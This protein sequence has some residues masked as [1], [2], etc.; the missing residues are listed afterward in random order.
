MWRYRL[1]FASLYFIQGATLAYIVNFQKPY[2]FAQG[3][4]TETLGLFTS[5]LLAP[6]ILKVFLGMLSDRVPWGRFGSRKP[7]MAIGL[8]LFALSYLILAF[9]EPGTHFTMFWVTSWFASLGLALFDTCA[10]GWAIDIADEEEQSSIQASMIVGKSLGLILMSLAFGRIAM[11][12]GFAIIFKI[13]AAMALVVLLIVYLVPQGQK[14]VKAHEL[15]TRWLD[16]LKPFYIYFALFAVVY[17][18][19]SFGTDGLVTLHLS[20]VRGAD[21]LQLGAYGMARGF[22]ALLGALA[23]AFIMH[24]I[25]LRKSQWL[26]LAMLGAGCLL[27]LFELPMY[28]SGVVWGVCWGFQETAFVTLAMRFSE[29]AWAATFF[30]VSMIFSNLG[31]SFGEA[32][33]GQLVPRLGFDYVFTLFALLAWGSVVFVPK[34]LKP[35]GR[36]A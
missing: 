5:S 6:F 18:I 24:K 23:Y 1:F 30:A 15:A 13:L 4:A 16:L 36:E 3:I 12:L 35:L 2:L 34:M 27:P 26:A 25:G 10:D 32:L 8:G 17:S 19:A 20:E 31:T 22:G 14:K 33:G 21:T 11:S 9:V 28:F 29:G 7:Y